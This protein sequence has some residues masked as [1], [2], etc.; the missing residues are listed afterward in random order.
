MLSMHFEIKDALKNLEGQKKQLPYATSVAINRTA[1]DVKAAEIAEIKSVIDNPTP[2]ILR[3]V[4]IKYSSKSR[5]E[6]T[7]YLNDKA[8]KGTPVAKIL[9]AHVEGGARSAKPF[10]LWLQNKG[11]MPNGWK[12]VPSKDLKLDRY[13]NIS[14]AKINQIMAGLGNGPNDKG[15]A[16]FIM[17]NVGIYERG[18]KKKT[19]KPVAIFVDAAS[20]K[21]KYDYV[22]V[23]TRTVYKNFRK[24]FERAWAEANG[25]GMGPS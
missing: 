15:K 5:L 20:Y 1:N 17:K 12:L 14:R 4:F 13:G 10:E 6:A 22:G 25:K 16:F 8:S 18:G 11:Y 21:A 19:V 2:Y 24:N 7:I 23:G 3:G 9:A